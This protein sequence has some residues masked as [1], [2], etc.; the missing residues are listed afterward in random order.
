MRRLKTIDEI[1]EE[2][3]DFGLVITNDI[4]LETALN[5]RISTA[6]V[7]YLAK[8]PRHIVKQLGSAVLGR[9]LLSDLEVVSKISEETGLGFRQVYSEVLNI[10]TIRSHT[11]EVG[12]YIT[13]RNARRI[14]ESYR[15]IPTL[16]KAMAEFDPDDPHVS[17]YFD[18]RNGVAVV[19]LDLFDDLDKHCIPYDYVEIDLFT[20]GEFEID[21]I[22]EVGND[23]QLADNA[24]SLI[25]P[26]NPTDYA[27]V[28]SASS[29]I[30]DSVRTALYRRDLPFVNSLEVRD[31]FQIRDYLSFLMLSMEYRTIRVKSVK[32]LFSNYNGFFKPGKEEYLLHKQDKEDLR[33][34]GFELKE[35]MRAIF[36]DGMSFGEVRDRLCDRH[37]RTQVTTILRALDMEDSIV[38]PESVSELRFA[39]DN[40]NEL[41]HNEELPDNEKH[42]VLLADCKNSVYVDRPVVIFLGM[43]Q[44]W[45]KPVVGRRYLDADDESK[46]NAIRLNALIQQGQKRV[47]MV[48]STKNG[49]AVRP[50]LTFD[51]IFN[52]PCED[53]QSICGEFIR[54]RWSKNIEEIERRKGE[55]LILDQDNRRRNFSKSTFNNYVACPRRY[56][57]GTLLP[58][59]DEEHTEF[60]NLVHEFAE[61][62]ACYPE[63][64]NEKGVDYFVDLISDRYAGLSSPLMEDLDHERLRLAM[65]NVQ[66]FLDSMK[67]H[68]DL[69]SYNDRRSNPNR[70]LQEFGLEMTS[71]LCESDKQSQLHPIHGKFDLFWKGNVFDYKT[72]R[73]K[74]PDQIITAMDL[75][76][77]AK[78]PEFQP[79]IYLALSDEFTDDAPEFNLFYAMGG[80]VVSSEEDYNIWQNV[81][82][83]SVCPGSM[84]DHIQ[85]SDDFREY[86]NSIVS[87]AMKDHSNRIIDSLDPTNS[88]DPSEWDSDEDYIDRICRSANKN[89]KTF[90]KNL[91][92]AIRKLARLLDNGFIKEAEEIY[93]PRESLDIFLSQLDSLHD[94]AMGYRSTEYPAAPKGQVL[95]KDCPFF[96]ACTK[97]V[98]RVENGG[99]NDE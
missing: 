88:S 24:A 62:Y 7:G 69:D 33:E 27:I 96:P 43:E 30:A 67:V 97:D 49:K 92:P 85:N 59:P 25:D 2:V 10:R 32:E 16:E 8:T 14:Y 95:C 66:R 89:D 44:E 71:D 45:N 98:V 9:P 52:R 38:T 65:I 36:E 83:I 82:H 26:E 11:S 81:R 78:Y 39:I 75:E 99:D 37:T 79:L 48:N 86:Y 4:A 76:N 40:V 47:Y 6:R 72:G 53:F 29:P 23:R 21:T 87:Q 56:M 42:G 15:A 93:V 55:S 73:S 5:N 1:Y 80:D 94:E 31:L 12:S 63:L 50:C 77:V 61:L 84:M 74:D 28:M 57:L 54:G 70:F 58:T 35:L 41:K 3:K 17:W 64:V 19:G 46:K 90:R 20:D 34:H 51:L 68:L 13:T 91:K 60:G 22:Y 18:R